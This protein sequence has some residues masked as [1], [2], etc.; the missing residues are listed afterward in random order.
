MEWKSPV[1]MIGIDAATWDV[2]HPLVEA[3]DL[4]N[5]A[6]LMEAGAW[7][8]LQSFTRYVSPALWTSIT[9]G[10]LP[11]K[12]GVLDFYTATRLDMR[13]PTLYDI[14]GGETGKVGLF[15]W[16]ASWPPLANDGF[17]VPDAV[18]RTPET[19]PARLQF[20]NELLRPSGFR[21]YLNGGKQLLRHR[22]RSSTW[23]R[24]I[25]EVAY[26]AIL[27]PGQ[28]DWW[29]RR[30][31]IETAI[32]SD[33]FAD[34][35]RK[36]QPNFAAI[37]LFH[38]DDLSHKYWRYREPELFNDVA[39]SDVRKFGDVIDKA[40]IEADRA[41]GTILKA[42]PDDTLVI[43]VSDH[44]QQAGPAQD[45]PFRMS[46]DILT[47]LGSGDD[48]WLTYI[49]YSAFLRSRSTNGS[50]TLDDLTRSLEQVRF[51]SDGDP[52]FRVSK[53]DADQ[54]VVD[55]IAGMETNLDQ[56]V[57][58]PGNQSTRLGDIVFTDGR[59]S[60]V[61]SDWGILIVKGPGVR[62]GHQIAEATILDVAPTVL[63]LRGQPV[64]EDM[65]GRVIEDLFED[66][67]LAR[68]PVRSI[69]SYAASHDRERVLVPAGGELE[70]LERRLR[71]L[72]YL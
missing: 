11:E 14:L 60:G 24:A 63:A 37:L 68:R 72:G 21:S 54:L 56:R 51:E 18:A 15:R 52:V 7:G 2:M 38:T 47:R 40:Y 59:L 4:P 49:G 17:T 43:V 65:D 13:A 32:Y 44:G 31:L 5:I 62:K 50:G 29:Y 28:L 23:L 33:V 30:R 58:L 22:V 8:R 71:D 42:V 3:G 70:E 9:T 1:L 19:Y 20:L 45:T 69:G 16:F 53:P 26:E 66:G 34:L 27:R 57:A 35:L 10:K 46:Q 67:F 12:H 48:V 61:H 25:G 41:I 36:H 6:G 39:P 64:A 55:V